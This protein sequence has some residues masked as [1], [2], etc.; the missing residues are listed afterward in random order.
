MAEITPVATLKEYILSN[1]T[2]V[3]SSE[4]LGFYTANELLKIKI[5][6][7]V[8]VIAVLIL[9]YAFYAAYMRRYQNWI[10]QQELEERVERGE[11]PDP[12]EY[13]DLPKGANRT[14][15]FVAGGLVMVSGIVMY[16]LPS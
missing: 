2:S 14:L 8:L 12:S 7:G 13:P 1:G 11:T 9:T 16:I 5:A 10:K 15:M 3:F 4:Q 6:G